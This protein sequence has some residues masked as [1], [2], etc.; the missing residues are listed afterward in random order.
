MSIN[1]SKSPK[2][3]TTM[4]VTPGGRNTAVKKKRSIL[5]PQKPPHRKCVNGPKRQSVCF[6]CREPCYPS[7]PSS[8]TINSKCRYGIART[9]HDN[10][11]YSLEKIFLDIQRTK[12]LSRIQDNNQKCFLS[13]A[14]GKTSKKPFT[15]YLS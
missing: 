9:A 1:S 2:K 12:T 13:Y 7:L 4:K 8:S 11:S 5:S 10:P 14:D 15:R 6:L 3:N